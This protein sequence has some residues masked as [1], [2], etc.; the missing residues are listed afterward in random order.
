MANNGVGV[1]GT[2]FTFTALITR[3]ADKPSTFGTGSPPFLAWIKI[4][5]T[6]ISCLCYPVV[7]LLHDL[8]I[9]VVTHCVMALVDN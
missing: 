2:G 9:G 4:I 7:V 3:L 6:F 5:S 8:G 1:L